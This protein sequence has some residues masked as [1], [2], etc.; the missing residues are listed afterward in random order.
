MP[1]KV[2]PTTGTQGTLP[3]ANPSTSKLPDLDKSKDHGK[4]VDHD[5]NDSMMQDD[6]PSG[7]VREFIL[8]HYGINAAEEKAKK[9]K[10]VDTQ[11]NLG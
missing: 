2:A 10:R 11:I 5:P 7:N 9:E 3:K 8:K 1:P 4:H 6:H